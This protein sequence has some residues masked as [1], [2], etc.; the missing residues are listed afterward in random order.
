MAYHFKKGEKV[1]ITDKHNVYCG[2]YGFV[3]SFTEF[4]KRF[5]FTVGV[6]TEDGMVCFPVMDYKLSKVEDTF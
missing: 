3:Q 1:L 6:Y 5:V 4:G 2:D